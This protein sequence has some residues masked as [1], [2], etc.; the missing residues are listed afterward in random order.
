VFMQLK[1]PDG[2][3]VNKNWDMGEVLYSERKF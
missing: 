1:K 3:S 2:A